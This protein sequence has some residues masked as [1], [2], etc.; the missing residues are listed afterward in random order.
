MTEELTTFQFERELCVIASSPAFAHLEKWYAERLVRRIL[1]ASNPVQAAAELGVT[2]QGA[3]ALLLAIQN[4]AHDVR[5]RNE[6]THDSRSQRRGRR[7]AQAAGATAAGGN[8]SGAGGAGE[9]ATG[10]AATG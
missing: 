2:M 4:A 8:G 10:T 5:K 6:V 3:A 9:Q 1:A 7:A